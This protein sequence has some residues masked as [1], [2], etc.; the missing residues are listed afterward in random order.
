MQIAMSL[1]Y[2]YVTA[3]YRCSVSCLPL[4]HTDETVV[5]KCQLPVWNTLTGLPPTVGVR[6]AGIRSTLTRLA[7]PLQ[8]GLSVSG[9]R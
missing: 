8:Y 4:E 2:A 1:E 3:A 7:Y 9:T 5:S 6:A